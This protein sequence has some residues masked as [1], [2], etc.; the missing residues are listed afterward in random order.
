MHEG[1]RRRLLEQ[2]LESERPYPHHLMEALLFYAIPRKDTNATAHLLV[3]KF[4][5]VYQAVNA[6]IDDL[7][8]VD[9]VGKNTA[10]FLK[11]ISLVTE[12]AA[13]RIG[14][15]HITNTIEF[16]QFIAARPR[17]GVNVIEVC[18][19][20]KKGNVGRIVEYAAKGGKSAVINGK[21][22]LRDVVLFRPYGIFVASYR[23][24]EGV[25][26]EK[27]DDD[28]LTAILKVCGICGAWIYDFV[29][30]DQSGNDYSYFVN[31]RL[32]SFRKTV[33]G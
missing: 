22:F 25:A 2:V 28:N 19:L 30:A 31:D 8:T 6:D 11:I 5:G 33:N 18:M 23:N 1:H 4:G 14:F 17:R 29:I 26:P 3:E 24:R 20:D 21:Q 12:R 27:S 10:S 7:V 15:A 32:G 9:G 16:R 13:N